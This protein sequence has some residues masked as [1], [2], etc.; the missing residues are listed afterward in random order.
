MRAS[1]LRPY[2][3]EKTMLQKLSL[4]WNINVRDRHLHSYEGTVSPL[5]IAK[6]RATSKRAKAARKVAR[7]N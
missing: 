1:E 5:T 4:S 6:R 3:S 7:H 2:E